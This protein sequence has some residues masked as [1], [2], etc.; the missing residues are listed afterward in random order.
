MMSGTKSASDILLH[1]YDRK[2]LSHG[3]TA[4]GADWPNEADRRIRSDVMLDVIGS[5]IK[6]PAVLC[7][8]GCGTGGLLAHI[9]ERGLRN[10]IYIGADRSAAALSYARAKFPDATFIEI[11]VNSSE[12]DL[13][14]IACDYL[15]AN[16][17]FTVKWEM[18]DEQMWSFLK[19]TISRVW[20]L[21]R[22]GVAFN[23]MSKIV[24]WE[25]DD[26][27]HL[28]MDDAARFLHGLAGRRVRLRADYGLFEYTAFACKPDEAPSRPIQSE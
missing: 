23:V 7:D 1:N 10:I 27:F 11:D 14:Q 8:L 25:R 19:S 20:P 6:A 2:L 26:L 9:R 28:S 4:R 5:E 18:T 24:D 17:L 15:V 16:G 22:R 13:A 12:A 3:D 21:V